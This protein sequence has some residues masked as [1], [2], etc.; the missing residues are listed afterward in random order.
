MPPEGRPHFWCVPPVWN[1]RAVSLIPRFYISS[2]ILL[3]SPF[4]LCVLSFSE[5]WL[6]HKATCWTGLYI[7]YLFNRQAWVTLDNWQ[8]KKILLCQG[9]P[10]GGI[11]SPTLFLVINDLVAE[12]PRGVKAVLY[13]DDLVL[14]CKEEHAT[15]ATYRMQQALDQLATWAERWCVSINMDKSS[16]MLFTLSN[17]QKAGNIKLG[18]TPLTV[19]EEAT[20]LSVTFDKRMT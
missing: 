13:A 11:L 19:E 9:V 12:L 3:P 14:W 10:Q 7:S 15:T 20:Y 4:T 5:R 6:V 17:K 8:N 18:D 16:A 1:L 2:P